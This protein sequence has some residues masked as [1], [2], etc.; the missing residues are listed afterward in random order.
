LIYLPLRGKFFQN[1]MGQYNELSVYKATYD[2]LLEMFPFTKEFSKEFKY[3]VGE[4]LKKETIELSIYQ[5]F[6]VYHTT[7]NI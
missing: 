2:L 4:S 5:R 3:T 7:L 6:P 1:K